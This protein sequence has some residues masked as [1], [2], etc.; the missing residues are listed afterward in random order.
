MAC[1]VVRS[2]LGIWAHTAS[3][4][5]ALEIICPFAEL[6]KPDVIRLGARLPLERTLS[7]ARPQ[8]GQHCGVC[9][10]CHERIDA[11]IEAG[12]QDPTSYASAPP[13]T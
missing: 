2:L 12:I 10:K 6:T 7:C 13:Q 4:S 3:G 8:R 11:F 1:A 9:G 5:R